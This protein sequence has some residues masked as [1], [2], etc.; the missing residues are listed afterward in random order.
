V[1]TS[2]TRFFN[3]H[4]GVFTGYDWVHLKDTTSAGTSGSSSTPSGTRTIFDLSY[5]NV[6]TGFNLTFGTRHEK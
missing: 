1:A 2:P 4:A 5:G 3:N 6:I